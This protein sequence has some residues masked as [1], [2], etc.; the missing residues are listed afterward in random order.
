MSHPR[1]VAHFDITKGQTPENIVLEPDGSAD[2]TFSA[3]RQIANV[4]KQGHTRILAALPA[5]PNPQTP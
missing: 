4:T 3:A 5:E 2:L 1:I